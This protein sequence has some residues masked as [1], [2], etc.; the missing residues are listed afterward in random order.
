MKSVK[1]TPP[2]TVRWT[3]TSARELLAGTPA[4]GRPCP[5]STHSLRWCF[6][7]WF[8]C[9][10]KVQKKLLYSKI[11][12][13]YCPRSSEM[14]SGSKV[15]SYIRA[16][17]KRCYSWVL[18]CIFENFFVYKQ[19]LMIFVAKWNWVSA[20]Q[21]WLGRKWFRHR[22][23]CFFLNFLVFLRILKDFPSGCQKENPSKTLGKQDNLR[24]NKFFEIIPRCR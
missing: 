9:Y 2:Q 14:E 21:L 7:H 5:R 18:Y 15:H 13:K 17:G 19:I 6:L 16:H 22:K 10:C 8:D 24:K 23:S 12:L 1:E 11:S 4:R 3:W 20:F